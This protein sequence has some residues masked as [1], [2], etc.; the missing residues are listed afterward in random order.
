M[1]KV[2]GLCNLHHSPELGELTANRPLAST[3]FLGRYAFIDFTLSNFSNSEID[4][5]G[6]LVQNGPRSILKHL[7]SANV[8]NA[9]TKLGYEAIM[10]NEKMANNSRYNHDINNIR[11]NDW[12]F[13]TSL[14]DYFVI[15]PAHI[16]MSIDYREVIENHIAANAEITMVYTHINNGKTS[17]IGSNFVKVSPDH[18][19]V[20]IREN[21]GTL[22]EADISLE[23][24]IINRSKLAELMSKASATSSF[25]GLN[26]II[27]FTCGKTE[28]VHAFEYK[29][30]ARCF[31]SLPHYVEYS[32]ELLDY[33]VRKQL[34]K[35]EWPI[36]T[37]T[38]DTPPSKYGEKAD[39]SDCFIANG[40]SVNGK[41]ERS[42]LSRY[43]TVA[44]GAS[45]KNSIILTDT[46]IGAGVHLDGVVV[47]KYAHIIHP[48]EI[49]SDNGYPVYIK[50]GDVI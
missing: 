49:S 39:V 11:A 48:R 22:N 19:V 37:V 16:V 15:A 46:V 12:M 27:A 23:T 2:M 40:A 9:N 13:Y 26:D 5:I 45:V 32:L 43:V 28:K 7:G 30:Y 25:F 18:E 42:I 47:D 14:P 34:F 38:H 50:Q 8:W 10:Y 29:G 20:L 1:Y 31:D 33:T 41:V 21:K 17:F 24:F 4:E 6:I 44:E 3:S 35:P 36:Y